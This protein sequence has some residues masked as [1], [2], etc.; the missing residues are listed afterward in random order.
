MKEPRESAFTLIELLIILAVISLIAVL[1]IPALHNY[2]TQSRVP[3]M[4]RQTATLLQLARSEAVRRGV[5]SVVEIVSLGETDVVRA[6]VDFDDDSEID[7]ADGDRV[8]ATLHFPRWVRPGG[9][10]G[11]AGR[12]D[13]FDVSAERAV[14]LPDGSVRDIGAFRFRGQPGTAIASQ[15]L[16]VRISPQATGKVQIRAWSVVDGDWL[17]P[18]AH[19]PFDPEPNEQHNLQ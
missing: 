1:T 18:K 14:F 12:V 4:A 15:F 11:D 19:G 16:E 7:P 3:T 10:G 6:F 9:P 13:G 2:L 8:L 5:P 17:M